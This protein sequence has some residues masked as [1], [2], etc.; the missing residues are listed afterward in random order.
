MYSLDDTN[1]LF[2]I[3][4][5]LILIIQGSWIFND[6]SKR[7]ENKWIW[8][9]FGCLNVPTSLL[10]YILVTRYIMKTE[11]CGHCGN[12]VRTNANYCSNCG[13]RIKNEY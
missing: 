5:F 2:W 10:I 4:I 12:K 7:G 11:N 9:L 1:P 8:G 13:Q 3:I 6:A